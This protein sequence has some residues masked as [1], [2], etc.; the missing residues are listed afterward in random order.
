MRRIKKFFVVLSV[1]VLTVTLSACGIDETELNNLIFGLTTS[2]NS[3]NVTT[4]DTYPISIGASTN[5][6]YPIYPLPPTQNTANPVTPPAEILPEYSS[7]Q[8]PSK[9]QGTLVTPP[10][11]TTGFYSFENALSS[12]TTGVYLPYGTNV[13]PFTTTTNVKV[14]TT[15]GKTAKDGSMFGYMFTYGLQLGKSGLFDNKSLKL[16]TPGYQQIEI[17]ASAS[18]SGVISGELWVI[19]DQ[20][21]VIDSAIIL[22]GMVHSYVLTI[23]SEGTYALV[24]SQESGINIWGVSFY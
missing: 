21:Y 16:T 2:Y 15:V 17:Y 14:A 13:Y 7:N 23:P 19:D 10:S 3:S 12:Y 24:A 4:S 20:G 22:Y 9:S 5:S 18:S 6:N 1:F 8:K 11:Q